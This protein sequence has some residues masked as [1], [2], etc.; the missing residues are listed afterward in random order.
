MRER[1][2]GRILVTGPLAGQIPS[3]C[4][5]AKAL[6]ASFSTALSNEFRN[7]G[8]TV[9]CLTSG[10]P[11]ANMFADPKD[12]AMV[13]YD[14]MVRGEPNVVQGLGNEQRAIQFPESSGLIS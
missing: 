7:S 14:A 9:T 6:L 11:D 1:A 5:G 8:V 10:A 12:V 13:G 2:R 4:S 3:H